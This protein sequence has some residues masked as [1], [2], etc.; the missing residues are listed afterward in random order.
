MQKLVVAVVA[1]SVVAGAFLA[2]VAVGKV[3]PPQPKFIAAEEVKWDDLSG[4]KVGTLVGDYKKG[5]YGA[6]LRIP[7][8]YTSPLHAHTGAYEAVE[9]SGTSSHWM[10]GEDGTKAKKMTPG[11]YWTIPGKT[12]HVSS[13]AT[14]TDCVMYIWQKVKFDA[15]PAKDAAPVPTGSA[16]AAGMGSG[17]AAKATVSAGAAVPPKAGAGSAAA[18]PKAGTGS[19]AAP[20]GAP[21]PKASGAGAGS[22][23]SPKK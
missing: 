21:A 17:S 2:G 23:T 14:G 3:A 6:L 12:E 20:P 22:Q 5:P 1:T 7:A 11:S 19:A 4:L 10:R 15:L 8:G 18:P 9:I 16:T 13:C